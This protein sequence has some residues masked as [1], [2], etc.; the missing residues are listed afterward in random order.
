MNRL[1]R[2]SS[3]MLREEERKGGGGMEGRGFYL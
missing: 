2:K 1:D 3:D